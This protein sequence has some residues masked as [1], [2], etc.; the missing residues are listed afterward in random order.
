M[1]SC[2]L[3]QKAADR[4]N[5]SKRKD[6]NRLHKKPR[7]NIFRR[8][9]LRDCCSLMLLPLLHFDIWLKEKRSQQQ[10]VLEFACISAF[11]AVWPTPPSVVACFYALCNGGLWG[12]MLIKQPF[13]TYAK[14]ESATRPK[15]VW[16]DEYKSQFL[17][18]HY[19]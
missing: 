6:R 17:P 10:R 16:E 19:F 7:E 11:F 14:T 4:P 12:E 1:L 13:A 5:P 15:P 8:L 9:L 2:C 18:F 3:G